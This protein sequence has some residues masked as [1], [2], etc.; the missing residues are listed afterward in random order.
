VRVF[1]EKIGA[2]ETHG[3]LRLGRLRFL[4]GILSASSSLAGGAR[5]LR[6]TSAEHRS[7]CAS[8]HCYWPDLGDRRKVCLTRCSR[9]GLPIAHYS[10]H[11]VHLPAGSV[12]CS[13]GLTACPG[14]HAERSVG[15]R[16]SSPVFAP[17]RTDHR[18][19]H[20]GPLSGQAVPAHRFSHHRAD[21]HGRGQLAGTPVLP[22]TSQGS[23]SI[24]PCG[25]TS[26]F[27]PDSRY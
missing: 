4:H 19:A 15:L 5:L 23:P 2:H 16:C 27:V 11:R 20:R 8:V 9:R 22:L 18:M 3:R 17:R 26:C 12:R 25:V 21:R 7:L 1:H 24:A 14:L 6:G 10:P 13:S